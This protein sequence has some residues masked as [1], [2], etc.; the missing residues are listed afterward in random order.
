MGLCSRQMLENSIE[1]YK[2]ILN[3]L[4]TCLDKLIAEDKKERAE[5]LKEDQNQKFDFWTDYEKIKEMYIES[6]KLFEKHADLEMEIEGEFYGPGRERVV[7]ENMRLKQLY[8]SRIQ[9]IRQIIKLHC[10]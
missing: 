7:G 1:E 4:Y 8:D 6:S 3:T 5:M 10:G 2:G 9:E